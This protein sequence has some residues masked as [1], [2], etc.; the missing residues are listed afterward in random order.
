M[1]KRSLPVAAHEAG[2]AAIAIAL[3]IPI[4]RVCL[5]PGQPDRGFCTTLS[6]PQWRLEDATVDAGGPA[7]DLLGA[8]FSE[9][10]RRHVPRAWGADFA[11]MRKCGFSPREC[12][13]LVELAAGML[14]GQRVRELHRR[15]V[16][17]LIE[18][19]LFEAEIAD[20][21]TGFRVEP[22]GP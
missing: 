22:A 16:E 7:A 15:I 14:S 6:H 10:W 8:R 1:R 19:D 13:T 12:R 4:L 9:R 20:L 18:R 3:G 11:S 2:H 5:T 17:A 21:A